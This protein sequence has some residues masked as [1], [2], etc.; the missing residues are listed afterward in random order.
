VPNPDALESRERE[1]GLIT[2]TLITAVDVE[3]LV[4]LLL[5][6][7]RKKKDL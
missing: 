2:V 1:G 3:G 7:T 5:S 6:I 4:K